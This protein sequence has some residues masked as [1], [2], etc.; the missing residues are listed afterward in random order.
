MNRRYIDYAETIIGFLMILSILLMFLGS[1]LFAIIL[2][3]Q[4]VM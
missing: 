2:I 4:G 1:I 3:L